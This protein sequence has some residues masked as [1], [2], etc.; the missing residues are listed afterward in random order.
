MLG[1]WTV[2]TINDLKSLEAQGITYITTNRPQ[3]FLL[4]VAKH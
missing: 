1:S 2:N 4:E 3:E